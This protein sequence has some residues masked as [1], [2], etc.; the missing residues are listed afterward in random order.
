MKP[1]LSLKA[2]LHPCVPPEGSPQSS[3]GDSE[4]EGSAPSASS[5][6]FCPWGCPNPRCEQQ[7]PWA[8]RGD[9]LSGVL[10]CA[11]GTSWLV[12]EAS[13][14]SYGSTSDHEPRRCGTARAGA[15]C[16]HCHH[17]SCSTCGLITAWKGYPLLSPA[18]STRSSASLSGLSL[19][20]A[21]L[22]LLEV[23]SACADVL[24]PDIPWAREAGTAHGERICFSI[25]CVCAEE[26]PGPRSGPC[27]TA[28]RLL[29]KSLCRCHHFG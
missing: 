20:L 21:L 1:D 6:S 25:S 23:L 24:R 29:R 19:T 9:G 22:T 2:E 17:H 11:S 15:D 12:W 7:A 13:S 5:G 28:L 18:C 8:G 27:R 4:A 3:A 26:C 16:W 14:C 10:C